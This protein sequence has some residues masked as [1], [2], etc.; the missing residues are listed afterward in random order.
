MFFKNFN[1]R[2]TYIFYLILIFYFFF[3][4]YQL[5]F[6]HWSSM[7]DHD[8]YIL[9]N[10]LLISSGLEQEGRDHPAFTT[11]LLHG[12][13]YKIVN[14]FQSNFSTN[15]DEIL[16]SNK[17]NETFQ[18]YIQV[19][20]VINYFINFFLFLSFLKLI[21]L[22]KIK[23]EIIFVASIIFLVSNWFSLSFFSLRSE[24]LSLL[25]VILSIIFVIKTDKIE[26]K[27]YFFVGIFFL[28]SMFTKIQVIFFIT[29]LVFFITTNINNEKRISN[30]YLF[31][32]I[33]VNYLIYSL[34]LIIFC[35][36]VF[37][38]KIQEFV[39]FE[40]NK[41]L[42][43]FVFVLSFMI[44]GIYFFVTSKFKIYLLK[45]KF[46][47]LS[48]VLHGFIF[49]FLT[50]LL[51]DFLNIIPVNDFIYLRITNPIHY[52]SEMEAM[53]ANGLININFILKTI[54]EILSSYSESLMELFLLL[55]LIV[56]TLKKYFYNKDF[57]V[58]YLLSLLAIFLL[59]T[60]IY[61]LRP[62]LNYHLYYTFCYLIV[63]AVSLNYFNLRHIR[64]ISLIFVF[65]FLFNNDL[66]KS[67]SIPSE[68]RVSSYV[69]IFERKNLM[70]DICKEFR[71]K[72]KSE[73]IDATLAYLIYWHN[74]F[75]NKKINSLCVELKI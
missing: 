39:R 36:L 68:S 37:Q 9:Y 19:S 40:K 50:I 14:L 52:L 60:L 27:N 5:R 17:M 34:I 69:K 62:R 74:K 71:F 21:Q 31:S 49:G 20:R 64:F 7:M 13:T 25:F 15:I 38:L 18:F 53:F 61:G 43:L 16:D 42:D 56:L 65:I 11:F 30:Q 8:F 24:N 73:Q 35:Y 33:N 26:L 66:L 2:E 67:Y 3:N 10:S 1:L 58:S 29:F 46:I 41:Y 6:N 4:L 70:I 55:T 63:L 57:S 47:L 48:M 44:I 59:I 28:L 32:R 54:L 23:K 75:D 72:V 12:Y 45:E 22:L 51:F